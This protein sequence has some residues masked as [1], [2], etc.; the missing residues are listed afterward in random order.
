MRFFR[1]ALLSTLISL[2]FGVP[3]SAQSTSSLDFV[4]LDSPATPLTLPVLL[5]QSKPD[6]AP[7][8]ALPN[9]PLRV[10]IILDVD[11]QGLPQHI[12]TR[13]KSSNKCVDKAAL[14]AVQAYRFTPAQQNGKNAVA[15]I[16]LVIDA[17][18]PAA[19]TTTPPVLLKS[20]VPQNPINMRL[21]R[22]VARVKFQVGTD[23]VPR[24]MQ[25]VPPNPEFDRPATSAV[26]QYRY[27]PAMKDGQP[28]QVEQNVDVSFELERS[29]R[30]N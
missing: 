7:C 14:A 19:G 22:F 20:V 21:G 28:V 2:A 27:W 4:V 12:D 18:A 9:K 6:F 11:A 26:S 15:H 25:I 23:G 17:V 30:I 8:G 24:E 1:L 10:A 13:S 5:T 16:G 29:G 3:A